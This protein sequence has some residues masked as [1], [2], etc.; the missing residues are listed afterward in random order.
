ME[1]GNQSGAKTV[2]TRD[3][4]REYKVNI[5]LK[6]PNPAGRMKEGIAINSFVLCLIITA[7]P[8]RRAARCHAR[9]QIKR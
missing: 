9:M 5:K 3:N 2:P 7:N 8:L 6:N 1:V 4:S